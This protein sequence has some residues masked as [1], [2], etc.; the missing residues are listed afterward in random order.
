MVNDGTSDEND[1][2]ALVPYEPELPS[3]VSQVNVYLAKI[4]PEWQAKNLIERVR[5]LIPVDASSACQRLLNAAFHDLKRK[6][7][8]VGTDLAADAA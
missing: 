8:I 2:V 4:R 3:E 7:Q 6:V 5:L 1:V